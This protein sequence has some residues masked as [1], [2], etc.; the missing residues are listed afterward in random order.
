MNQNLLKI[1]IAS[2]TTTLLRHTKQIK[3]LEKE[4][5]EIK[6]L[7]KSISLTLESQPGQA[8][9]PIN[10]ICKMLGGEQG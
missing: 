5:K 8:R 1:K 7:L 10:E 4:N 6:A 3:D 2:M 9:K